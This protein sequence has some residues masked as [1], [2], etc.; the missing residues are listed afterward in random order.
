MVGDSIADLP[1]HASVADESDNKQD[2]EIDGDGYVEPKPILVVKS[3]VS[4]G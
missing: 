4:F 2:A 1:L 3:Y